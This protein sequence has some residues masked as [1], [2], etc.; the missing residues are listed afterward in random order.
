MGQITL[1][2][3]PEIDVL[4]R[5]SGRAKRLSLRVSQLDGRVT[6]TLPKWASVRQAQAFAEEKADWISNALARRVESVCIL[7]GA[8]LPVEGVSRRVVLGTARSAKLLTDTLVVPEGRPGPATAALLKNLA[9]DRLSECVARYADAIGRPYGRLT[10]RDTRSR[11]GSCSHEGN[12]MFSWRL[13]LA[14]PEVLDYVAAHEVAHL[15]R[16]DHSPAFWSVVRGLCPVYETPRVWLR[17]QG[18][19]LHRYRFEAPASN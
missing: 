5:R 1:K 10:L 12:L 15:E 9:R 16:M 2:G 17:R 7:P 11:W 8:E 3:H 6:M 13:I 14:P 18:H 4:L 19:A